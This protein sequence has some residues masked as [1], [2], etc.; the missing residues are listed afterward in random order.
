MVLKIE[1]YF[2]SGK[3]CNSGV[4]GENFVPAEMYKVGVE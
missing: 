1:N 3:T 4:R 2:K